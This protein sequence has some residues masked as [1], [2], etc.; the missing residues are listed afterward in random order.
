MKTPKRIQPLVEEGLV[1]DVVRQLMSGKEATVYVVRCADE[2]RC[3]KVYKEAQQRNFR[4][5]TAYQEG[6]KV[7]NSRDAR[8]RGRGTRYG[9]RIQ[10]EAWQNAEVGALYRLAAAGVRVP[11]PHICFEGVLLMELVT[12]AAGD[13][14]P[15]LS[16]VEINETTALEIHA[17][18][19]D[20]VV[21]MLCAGVIHGDLSEYNILLGVDGPVII[22]LPQA[23][24]AAGNSSAAEMFERD[25]GNLAAYFG[26]FAPQLLVSEYGKEIWALYQAG[27]LVPG[28]KLCGR[29]AADERPA[30]PDAVL[31]EIA[32][33][34]KEQREEAALRLVEQA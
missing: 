23:V 7:K 2:L 31:R 32:L 17:A 8:A 24:D 6:R 15:R 5:S 33:A 11:R 10:E 27:L 26:R 25:V 13:A 4:Q 9:R 18:L 30:D 21:L 19:L 16:D 22:D 28:V 14:A 12:N 1:D 3:A 34:R 29:F 20:Q